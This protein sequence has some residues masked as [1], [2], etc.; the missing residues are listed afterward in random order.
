MNSQCQP[1]SKKHIVY[2]NILKNNLEKYNCNEFNNIN[3]PTTLTKKVLDILN[4]L[5]EKQK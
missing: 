1:N 2:I 5:I 4:V 3:E